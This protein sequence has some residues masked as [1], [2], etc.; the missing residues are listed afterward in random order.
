MMGRG[1]VLPEQGPPSHPTLAQRRPLVPLVFPK[2]LSHRTAKTAGRGGRAPFGTFGSSPE[3]P[4]AS[5]PPPG[6]PSLGLIQYRERGRPVVFSVVS[7]RRGGR[8]KCR[9]VQGDEPDLRPR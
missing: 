8:R 6:T 5:A 7:A 1:F 2:G 3:A 4:F 9:T